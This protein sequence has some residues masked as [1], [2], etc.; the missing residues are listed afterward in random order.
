MPNITILSWNIGGVGYLRTVGAERVPKRNAINDELKNCLIDKYHPDFILLQEVVRYENAGG[1]REDIVDMAKIGSGYHY[2]WSM[3]ID[4]ERNNHPEKWGPIRAE[5]GWGN[6]T[7]LAQGSAILWNDI[8]P[9]GSIWEHNNNNFSHDKFLEQEE[10]RLDNGIYAGNRDTEPRTATVSR[11]LVDK[12]DLLLVN[13]HLTTLKGEREGLPERDEAGSKI[14]LWQLDIILNGIVSRYNFWRENHK[15]F[16]NQPKP[17]WL[18]A[19]DFNGTE[20]SPEIQKLKR[21]RFQDVSPIEDAVGSGSG[22]KRIRGK[23]G[24]PLRWII[25]LQELSTMHLIRT[26]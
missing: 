19:G 23:K 18:L 4:T 13:L 11:F 5:G 21:M 1:V 12:R 26:K 17:F 6:N 25:F 24:R 10:V 7:Y 16:Q 3:V 14:R 9:H 20:I 2:H 8:I 22:T 15:K